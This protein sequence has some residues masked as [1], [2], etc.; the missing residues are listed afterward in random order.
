MNSYFFEKDVGKFQDLKAEDAQLSVLDQSGFQVSSLAKPVYTS[1]AGLALAAC[2]RGEEKSNAS[3]SSPPKN[4][5]PTETE[6]ARF[7]MQASFGATYAQ[8]QDV[9]NKGFEA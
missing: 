6:A 9:Q 2:G 3:V 7:L 8:V 4:P 1:M 5:G